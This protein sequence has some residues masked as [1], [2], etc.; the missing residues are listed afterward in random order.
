MRNIQ[1]R[2]FAYA[3][4]I[5]RS[6]F[7]YMAAALTL[8]CRPF[9]IGV[10]PDGG[11]VVRVD[12]APDEFERLYWRARC[13]EEDARC[14]YSFRHLTRTEARNFTFSSAFKMYVLGDELASVVVM[15]DPMAP[16][17]V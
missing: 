8:A 14:G 3:Y 17:P 9:T 6:E 4:P 11:R 2:Q 15:E 12:A 1:K 16:R 7:E 13:L 5:D 10:G